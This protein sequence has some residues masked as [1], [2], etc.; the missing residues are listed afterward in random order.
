MQ[1]VILMHSLA[2]E[3]EWD[4]KKARQRWN[5]Y[6]TIIYTDTNLNGVKSRDY[7]EFTRGLLW[8]STNRLVRPMIVPAV[9]T[10]PTVFRRIVNTLG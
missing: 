1:Q 3:C 9:K 2:K 5:P 7:F 10:L 4:L 6:S 8:A